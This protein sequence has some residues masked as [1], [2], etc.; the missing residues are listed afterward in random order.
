MNTKFESRQG[1]ISLQEEKIFGFISDFNNFRQF[2]P[3]DKINDYQS[4]Q[5]ECSFSVPGAGMLKLK[6]VEKEPFSLL[7][8][9]GEGMGNQ[10]FSFWI[11]LKKVEEMDT[12]VKLTLAADLNPV[13]KMMVAKP[14]E[15]FLDKFVTALENIRM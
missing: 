10:T 7:K 2:I 8:I 9:G 6:I 15:Q 5:E 14:M 13:M 1:K 4:S 11:Q 3:Q 12:R